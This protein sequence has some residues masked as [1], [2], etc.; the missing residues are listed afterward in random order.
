MG[1]SKNPPE[2]LATSTSASSR[3][4]AG[5]GTGAAAVDC[6]NNITAPISI[7]QSEGDAVDD[8]TQVLKADLVILCTG[9]QLQTFTSALDSVE[10]DGE[11]L[12][13]SEDSSDRV[14]Y[15]GCM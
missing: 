11:S 1:D 9:F 2:P 13:H 3:E 4:G 8:S 14:V 6:N 5:A 10:V 15:R 7:K 12:T